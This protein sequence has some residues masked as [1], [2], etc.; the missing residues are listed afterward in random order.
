MTKKDP[1]HPVKALIHEHTDGRCVITV[2]QGRKIITTFEQNH[3]VRAKQDVKDLF[4][5]IACKVI[6]LEK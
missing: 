6:K 5:D 4:G 2:S 3:V 1:Y